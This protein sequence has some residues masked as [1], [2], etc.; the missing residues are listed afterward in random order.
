M[1]FVAAAMT[2]FAMAAPMIGVSELALFYMF[3]GLFTAYSV[4]ISWLWL[5]RA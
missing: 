4:A 3:M 2:L 1:L 5:R